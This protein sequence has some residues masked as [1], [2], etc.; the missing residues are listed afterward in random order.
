MVPIGSPAL[1][2]REPI[3]RPS[4]EYYRD[5][6]NN[7]NIHASM[8]LAALRR[9]RG[10]T[11]AEMATRCDVSRM[12]ISRLEH[13]AGEL[14]AH[15]TGRLLQ[16]YAAFSN[17]P[18]AHVPP[19]RPDEFVVSYACEDGVSGLHI[20]RRGKQTFVPF[21]PQG[22]L[23]QLRRRAGKLGDVARK[24]GVSSKTLARF[25]RGAADVSV[26]MAE[27]LARAYVSFAD[28]PPRRSGPFTVQQE[29]LH[30]R[31]VSVRVSRGAL[32]ETHHVTYVRRL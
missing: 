29:W 24:L 25:E 27:R 13:G 22:T 16:A 8:N 20:E 17:V 23:A 5:T 7:V 1:E 31:L 10:V 21:R 4:L 32:T 30:G 3:Y 14:S 9:S 28:L 26:Q 18:P 11:Q 15:L 19:E 6:C 12:T 2:P